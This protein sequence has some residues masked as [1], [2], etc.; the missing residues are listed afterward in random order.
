MLSKLGVVRCLWYDVCCLWLCV[1]VGSWN[2]VVCSFDVFV[3]LLVVLRFDFV[4][5][6]CCLCSVCCMCGDRRCG[7]PFCVLLCVVRWCCMLLVCCCYCS[8]CRVSLLC[9]SLLKCRCLFWVVCIVC[10]C[11]FCCV[12]ALLLSV[13]P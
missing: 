10:W 12:R 2:V 3:G 8:R 1:V 4:V 5:I 9:S 13:A 11:C 7:M 6:L